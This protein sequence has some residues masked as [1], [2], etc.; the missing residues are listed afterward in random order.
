MACDCIS[1]VDAMLAAKNTKLSPALIFSTPVRV[2]VTLGTEVKEKKR[3]ARPVSM[4]PT[5]CPFCG[6]RYVPAAEGRS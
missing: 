5:F 3:G 6:E 4:L 2:V 1:K